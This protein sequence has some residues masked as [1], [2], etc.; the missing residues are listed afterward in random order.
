MIWQRLI[1]GALC[2]TKCIS[3]IANQHASTG[4]HTQ[5]HAPI[6]ELKV[7]VLD[8]LLSKSKIAN[9]QRPVSGRT[10]GVSPHAFPTQ[11]M[12]HPY[13]RSTPSHLRPTLTGP[14]R[15]S[16]ICSNHKDH[17]LRPANTIPASITTLHRA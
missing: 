15:T 8:L 12:R 11:S 1:P 17:R 16:T 3:H 4:R 9:H 2:A 10:V 6:L 13:P 5:I 14:R 7:L